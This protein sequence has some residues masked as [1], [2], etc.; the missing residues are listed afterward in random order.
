M[1][2]S[3]SAI[4]FSSMEINGFLFL[5]AISSL[6]R[7]FYLHRMH[8]GCFLLFWASLRCWLVETDMG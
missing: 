5:V 4:Y 1:A 6:P 8:D 3:P 7:R 2:A